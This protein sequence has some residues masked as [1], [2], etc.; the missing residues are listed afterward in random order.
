[1]QLYCYYSRYENSCISG[2]TT[3][4][5]VILTYMSSA[6]RSTVIELERLNH[7]KIFH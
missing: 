6:L 2:T 3:T 5:Y 4:M 1:M 7:S